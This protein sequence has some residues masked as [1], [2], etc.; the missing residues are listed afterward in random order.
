LQKKIATKTTKLDGTKLHK[1]LIAH[2]D[3]INN[4]LILHHPY[5]IICNTYITIK[6]NNLHNDLANGKGLGYF[7]LKIDSGT[8]FLYFKCFRL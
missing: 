4:Q 2:V 6:I 1:T 7:V 5:I 8:S 3:E